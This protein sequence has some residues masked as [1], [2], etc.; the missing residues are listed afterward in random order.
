MLYSIFSNRVIPLILL[1]ILLL[2]SPVAIAGVTVYDSVTS[3]NKPVQLRAITKGKFF[4]E[5]G[6]LVKFY[7]DGRPI[8]TTLSGGDGY[9]L[10]EHIP[11]SSGL[12][13]IRVEVGSDTDEGLLLVSRREERVILIEI[14]RTLL[15]LSL[16]NLFKPFSGSREALIKLSKRFRIIYLTTMMGAERSK[17]WLREKG[18][19]P[20]AILK[21]EGSRLLDEIREAG[22][23]PY[24]IVASPDILS[25]TLEIKKRFSLEDTEEGTTVKDWDELSKRLDG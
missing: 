6:K 17:E 16:R 21:W 18:F 14:E 19:P 24:A 9:A 2:H 12:K 1:P 25:E 3:V 4:P 5:G 13:Q 7:I 11:S 10:I 20:S 15:N 23:Q 22:I 8:G